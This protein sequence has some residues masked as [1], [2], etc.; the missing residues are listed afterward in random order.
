[1]IP[2]IIKKEGKRCKVHTA[3]EEEYEKKLLLKLHEETQE[4]TDEPCEEELADILEVIDGIIKYYNFSFKKI[5]MIK[6]KK[7]ASRGSFD[8]RIVL[9][10][11]LED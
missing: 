4:F 10:K 3:T 2:E 11:V 1:M 5:N 7:S 8:K 9:E 6:S